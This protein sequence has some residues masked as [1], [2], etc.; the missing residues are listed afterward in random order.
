MKVQY[1]MLD[2]IHV[3]FGGFQDIG[4]GGCICISEWKVPWAVLWLCG[5]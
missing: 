4:H 3:W 5:S 1:D 2:L